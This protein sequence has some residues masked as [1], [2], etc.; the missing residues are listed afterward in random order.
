MLTKDGISSVQTRLAPK[1]W[2]E[3]SKTV[4]RKWASKWWHIDVHA[5]I[6]TPQ[7]T[8][9]CSFSANDVGTPRTLGPGQRVHGEPKSLS[10]H[11]CASG[12]IWYLI[13]LKH[14]TTNVYFPSGCPK[15][16]EQMERD[17]LLVQERNQL[18]TRMVHVR[19]DTNPQTSQL[20]HHEF[21]LK[22]KASYPSDGENR[23]WYFWNLTAST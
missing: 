22:F 20:W 2:T 23:K 16:V 7:A 1:I 10:G 17:V 9:A 21:R 6:R 5:I 12:N 14:S 3:Y 8:G 13:L 11:R 15:W 18:S 19:V 4:S